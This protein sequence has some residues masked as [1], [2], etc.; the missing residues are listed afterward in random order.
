MIL[1]AGLKAAN[2]RNYD[3][4]IVIF[5]NGFQVGHKHSSVT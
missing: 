2:A 5:K 4:V 1:I 3:C